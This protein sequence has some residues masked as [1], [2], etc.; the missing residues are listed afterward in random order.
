ML[1]LVQGYGTEGVRPKNL[2]KLL[3][4]SIRDIYYRIKKLRR[5]KFIEKTK[6]YNEITIRMKLNKQLPS[7]IS[8]KCP[9]C[10]K[11]FKVDADA[12]FV[13]C[14]NKDCYFKEGKGGRFRFEVERNKIENEEDI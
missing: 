6:V 4:K 5:L 3:N 1:K 14:R 8:V 10:F 2:A 13:T 12:W 11:V 7:L 9:K